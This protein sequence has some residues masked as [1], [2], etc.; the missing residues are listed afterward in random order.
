MKKQLSNYS[1]KSKSI[2]KLDYY[3]VNNSED[4][5]WINYQKLTHRKRRNIFSHYEQ[6]YMHK[7]WN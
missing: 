4:S 3:C 2:I 1:K 7:W 6:T 5:P